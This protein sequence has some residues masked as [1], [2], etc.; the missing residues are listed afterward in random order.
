MVGSA[1]SSPTVSPR[2]TRFLV[3]GSSCR[4]GP[5]HG[6][7]TCGRPRAALAASLAWTRSTV[8][9]VPVV[10]TVVTTTSTP[11][12]SASAVP[13]RTAVR[14]CRSPAAAVLPVCSR[15]LIPLPAAWLHAEFA[16]SSLS[17][18]RRRRREVPIGVAGSCR[19]GGSSW[20]S[21][22]VGRKGCVVDRGSALVVAVA[23]LCLVLSGCS[24]EGDGSE[25]SPLGERTGPPPV[26]PDAPVAQVPDDLREA[27]SLPRTDSV[28]PEHG[29]DV[30]D[31]LHY[32]LDLT[33]A[34]GRGRLE[35]IETLT[36]RA[37]TDAASIPLDLSDALDVADLTLDGDSVAFTHRGN[38]LVLDIPVTAGDVHAV[39]IDYAGSPR[40]AKAP[41]DL[42]SFSDGVGWITD[43][44]GSTWMLQE[45]FGAFTWY[46]VNDH[47]SDKAL[48]D[49]TLTSGAG[50]T[51]VANGENTASRGQGQRRT[52]EWHLAEPASSY[53]VTVAFDDF[54][55]TGQT[56]PSGVPIQVWAPA[57]GPPL[58][59]DTAVTAEAMG[60]VEEILGP[61]PFETFGIVVAGDSSVGMETQTMV[62]LGD[63]PYSLSSP[64]IVH[65]LAHHWYGDS[66]TPSDWSE[67]WMNEGMATYLQA[68][69][70][71]EQEG[72]GIEEKLDQ[73]RD[74]EAAARAAAGPPGAYDPDR[75][76]DL[77]VYYGPA[78][79]WQEL[80]EELGDD[81]FFALLRDWPESQENDISDRYEYLAW[82]EEQTGEELDAFFADWLLSDTTPPTE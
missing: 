51:G 63:T 28:Y 1:A 21:E 68:M 50:L 61:Y 14:P 57:D 7:S 49:F 73:W 6:G 54:Q 4:C 3:A 39:R 70:E 30:V 53:L 69:W 20:T 74:A 59:G 38:D 25:A 31:A 67:V 65:E 58:P 60:W 11:A 78:L 16:S 37:A 9:P 55:V 82:I 66:V 72:I 40:P 47:P 36:F 34:P 44:D 23:A 5:I 26:R 17:A 48:Y 8:R 71:A 56:G 18:Q 42:S 81:P 10:G 2:E 52:T 29:N 77:N 32:D 24:G 79:M 45:P 46:A 12:A 15:V 35:A 80:R 13:I 33:W 64:V 62:T 75:F 41:N 43:D 27:V 76:V 22:V 19:T